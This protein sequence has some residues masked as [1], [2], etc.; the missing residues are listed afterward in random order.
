MYHAFI[1][2]LFMLFNLYRNGFHMNSFSPHMVR[3]HG[4]SLLLNVI[5]AGVIGCFVKCDW[6][7]CQNTQSHLQ[8]S[9][10]CTTQK[11]VADIEIPMFLISCR[12]VKSASSFWEVAI[13]AARDDAATYLR[14]I[15]HT[16][17]EFI[18]KR[19]PV[20][21]EDAIGCP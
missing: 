5:F 20:D 1:E 15:N 12:R 4:G 16:A 18:S 2:W 9:R 3:R 6:V 8:K 14:K 21:C 7:L 11:F 17:S 13:D 19:T 10:C